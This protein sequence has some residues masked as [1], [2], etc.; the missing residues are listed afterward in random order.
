MTKKARIAVIGAGWWATEYH[1]PFLKERKSDVDLVAVCRLGVD[2]LEFIKQRFDISIA[3]ES[4]QETIERSK[5]DGVI[6]SSPHVAHFEHAKAAIEAG[7]H[8]LVEKPMT[9][10]AQHARKLETMAM[11]IPGAMTAATAA[12]GTQEIVVMVMGTEMATM[13]TAMAEASKHLEI[14]QAVAFLP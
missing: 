4:F 1:I 6:V 10:N 13:V 5:P 2:E 9:V 14:T 11:E 8:V 7:A 3:S 12:T